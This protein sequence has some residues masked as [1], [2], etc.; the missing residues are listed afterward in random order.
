VTAALSPGYYTDPPAMTVAGN[1]SLD[2]GGPDRVPEG[3]AAV[4]PSPCAR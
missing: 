2:R 3:R 4:Y 1:T